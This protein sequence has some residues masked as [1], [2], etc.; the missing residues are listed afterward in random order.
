ML[1]YKAF[2]II[3]LVA[4]FAGLFY[5]PRL[6][7]Y[8][9]TTTDSISLARFKVM[10]SRLY[11]GITW[12]AA[13]LTTILG[14]ILIGFNPEYYLH[15]G[16][17]QIKLILVAFLWV[18]HLACGYFLKQ[19]AQDNNNRSA[20]FFRVYNEVPTLFLIAIVLLVVVKP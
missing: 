2:H 5:L 1:Y 10:E 11:Y 15:V 7:V 14:I 4:W 6:F 13:L 20:F 18:Y 19:F 8:H 17:M 9:A 12:P 16:W 3:S